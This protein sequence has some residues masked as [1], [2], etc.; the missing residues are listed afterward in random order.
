MAKNVGDLMTRDPIVL[1]STATPTDAACAMK[2]RDVGDV[3]VSQNGRLLGIVTDR[4]LVLRCLAE[5]VDAS[6]VRLESVCSTELAT[7]EP[8]D[9]IEDAIRLMEEHAVR[10]VPVVEN[11][12]AVGILSLGDLALARDPRSALALISSAEPNN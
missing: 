2:E 9:S 4:D 10:R 11:G 1:D 7:L 8:G 12:A 5:E 3:L 6:L